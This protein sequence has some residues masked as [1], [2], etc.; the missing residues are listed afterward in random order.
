MRLP[1]L[2]PRAGRPLGLRAQCPRPAPSS[3]VRQDGPAYPFLHT[4]DD[5]HEN[6][7]QGTW[8]RPW[9]CGS[10]PWPSSPRQLLVR[11][12]HHHLLPLGLGPLAGTWSPG[13]SAASTSASGDLKARDANPA[14]VSGGV[15]ADRRST[16][17]ESATCAREICPISPLV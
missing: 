16:S 7:A 5:T 14:P 10:R 17:R 11:F 1:G 8:P 9:A 2:G 12:S 4:K 13:T 15:G 6:S 3:P